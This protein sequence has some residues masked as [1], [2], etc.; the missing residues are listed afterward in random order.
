MNE[1]LLKIYHVLG[2]RTKTI[3]CR[4]ECLYSINLVI[5]LKKSIFYNSFKNI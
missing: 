3:L 2:V 1:W 4:N 5:L